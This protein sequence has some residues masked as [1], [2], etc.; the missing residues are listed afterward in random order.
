PVADAPPKNG[1]PGQINVYVPDPSGSLNGIARFVFN[2]VT[3]TISQSGVLSQGRGTIATALAIGPEGALYVGPVSGS[4]MTKIT[5]PA[6][7][8]SAATVVA[9]T[10]NGQGVNNMAFSGFNL[11]MTE[12]GNPAADSIS[13]TGANTE[14]LNAAP[15]LARGRAIPF[16]GFPISGTVNTK[17]AKLP[18]DVDV[19]L[20]MTVGPTGVIPCQTKVSNYPSTLPSIY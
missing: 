5:S 11:Y 20:A 18:I 13:R 2:P 19:P 8:P 9:N 3:E 7:A 14:I 17:G 1:T 4:T 15:D 12:N 6:T 10:L 16:T